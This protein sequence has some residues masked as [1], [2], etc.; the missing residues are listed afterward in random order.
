MGAE[1]VYRFELAE[2]V[3]PA[4][5][6]RRLAAIALANEWSFR[7]Y[8]KQ[9]HGIA[10]NLWGRVLNDPAD[11]DDAIMERDTGLAQVRT[12]EVPDGLANIILYPSAFSAEALTALE[13]TG[14][15]YFPYTARIASYE[16]SWSEQAPPFRV[17]LDVDRRITAH[18][19]EPRQLEPIDLYISE[20]NDYTISH[21]RGTVA[22]YAQAV[23]LVQALSDL[24]I[25]ELHDSTGYAD[26]HDMSG[27][28]AAYAT[29]YAFRQQLT[30]IFNEGEFGDPAL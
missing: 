20:A 29:D 28:I 4:D 5:V 11:Y 24:G 7:A 3:S 27:L 10:A 12:I 1:L 8:E 22:D 9:T 17:D 2:G 25:V 26:D 15:P 13:R 21:G 30:R 18:I 16:L 19:K 23:R 6:E 14:Q